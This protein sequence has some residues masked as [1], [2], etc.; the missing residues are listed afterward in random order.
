[1]PAVW[2]H[3]KVTH[4]L[5]FW[6]ARLDALIATRADRAEIAAA[7]AE[8]AAAPMRLMIPLTANTRVW[9]IFAACALGNPILFW[10]FEL[11]PLSLLALAGLVWHRKVEADLTRRFDQG[12]SVTLEPAVQS[13]IGPKDYH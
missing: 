4:L 5:D 9:A 7:Y 6:G 8:R 13:R 3:S 10:W 2:L 12:G 1:M 11:V